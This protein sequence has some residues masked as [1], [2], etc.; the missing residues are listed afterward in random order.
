MDADKDKLATEPQELIA[1][2]KERL[3]IA[4]QV[5]GDNRDNARDDLK[6]LAGN[7]WNEKAKRA[8]ELTG[9]PCLTINKLPT[10]LHQVTNDQRQNVPGI[11]VSPVDDNADEKVAEILQGLIR[12]IEYSSN[13][14]AAYDTAANSAAAVGFG[15]FGIMPCYEGDDSFDQVLKFRRFRNV[16][17][18]YMD[19]NAE[20]ADGS[21]SMWWLVLADMP[22]VEFK[23][24]YPNASPEHDGFGTETHGDWIK[25][26]TVRVAEYFR[27]VHE[28]AALVR[29]SNGETGW[30]DKLLEMPPGVSI[31]DERPSR[32][33]KVEWHKLTA[34]EVLETTE[35]LC[36]WIPMFPVFGDELD[37]DGK[38]IRTGLIRNARDPQQM[39][40]YW[41]TG[42]TE[43][44]ALRTK[45]PYIGAEGQF[46]GNEEAWASANLEALPYLEY[47]PVGVDG[48]L[49]PPPARQPM[50]D[51]PNG[52]LTMALHA[53]DNI[54]ATTGLFDSSLG[55]RGN[56]TSGIQEEAQ[57]RQG[58]IAN[59]HFTDNLNRA[60][61]HAGRCLVKMIPKYYDTQ[62]IV[63]IMGEDGKISSATVNEPTQEQDEFGRAVETIK[64]D[65]TVGEYDVTIKTGPP[66][67]TLRQEAARNMTE[68]AKGWPKFMD[69]AGDLA[70]R[71]QDWPGAE[72]IADRIKRTIPPE[73]RG[74]EEGDDSQP[75]VQTPN[76]PVPLEQAGQLIAQMQAQLQ[77][78]GQA[79]QEAQSGVAV[80]KVKEDGATQ[81]EQLKGS[82]AVQ[83]AEI[84]AVAKNDVAE[85][86]GLI[87]LLIAKLTPP[88]ALAADV[89]GDLAEDDSRPAGSPPVEIGAQG[90]A[91][92]MA[93]N[94]GPGVFAQ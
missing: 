33:R 62:R 76:G 25:Q 38:V 79:L 66:Y 47:K 35:I 34:V 22:R 68:L 16:F 29:L 84:N 11:K 19:P 65:M 77:Q 31:K 48:V 58:N 2:A 53:N 73:V 44:V 86:Q 52:Y 56:A 57:Q 93:S 1:E 91:S 14:D 10:F 12:H 59:F 64:N 21:D 60:I 45:T 5:D 43:E 26:D 55:A 4:Q 24:Q 90:N 18:V 88:P 61:R 41:M 51:V 32:R 39:Y 75:M 23:A 80:A 94:I 7:Q 72:E 27:I 36:D 20:E 15:F 85:L 74:Q 92:P 28:D 69:V 40:N 17:A 67:S 46:E 50:A 54:K 13:A 30:K 49:A 6:F 82:T 37:I 63:R 9:R 78:A 89:A 87:Q 70:I 81:R 8:R 71:A 3:R 83:V 42:A